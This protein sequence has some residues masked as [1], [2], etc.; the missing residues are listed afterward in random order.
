[1][2]FF[3]LCLASVE[4]SPQ[5]IYIGTWSLKSNWLFTSPPQNTLTLT[6][7]FG[8][9]AVPISSTATIHKGTAFSW[10]GVEV[11]EQDVF[12]AVALGHGFKAQISG[13]VCV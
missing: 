1:M 2:D 9:E 5:I 10:D 3:F 8:A 6:V 7:L 4:Q 13:Q 11:P 12:S